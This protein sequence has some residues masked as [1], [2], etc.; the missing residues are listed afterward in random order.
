MAFLIR[1][2][3]LFVLFKLIEFLNI[4]KFILEKLIL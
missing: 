2:I 4:N 1:I 3:M